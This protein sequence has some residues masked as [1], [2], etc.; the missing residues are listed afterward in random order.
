MAGSNPDQATRR[1]VRNAL[2]GVA[3]HRGA[4]VRMPVGAG[5]VVVEADQ[6]IV[7]VP[8]WIV[9]DLLPREC[10]DSPALEDLDKLETAPISSVHLWFD[11]PILFP[12]SRQ[13][14]HSQLPIQDAVAL[15]LPHV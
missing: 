8:H 4:I 11:R 3:V 6:V 15:E 10:R 12:V 13:G 2:D 1:V 7:A 9:R 5:G 14:L